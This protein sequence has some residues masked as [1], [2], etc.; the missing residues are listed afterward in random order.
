LLLL[1]AYV[2][3]VTRESTFFEKSSDT[4]FIPKPATQ[5]S[6]YAG[7]LTVAFCKATAVWDRRRP[8]TVAP[9]FSVIEVAPRMMPLTT[10]VE[11]R[12]TASET[13]QTIF[14][15]SAPPARVTFTADAVLSVPA[16]WKIQA[17]N[18][19]KQGSQCLR[20]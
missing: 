10:D 19:F 1:L 15:G 9:V 12:V 5:N 7:A 4:N 18:F 16:I 3:R 8:F 6:N 20:I 11:P 17:V 13:T 14:L 2:M